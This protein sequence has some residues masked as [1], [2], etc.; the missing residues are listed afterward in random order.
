[1][2]RRPLG[3]TALALAS[4]LLASRAEALQVKAIEFAG[5][6]E[7]Q[8]LNV[9][10]ALSLARTQLD[11]TSVVSENRLD[12]LMRLA[13]REVRLGLEAFG[14]YDAQVESKLVR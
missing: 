5:L 3:L 11:A 9:R 7:A 13:P 6:D 12:Y 1:M 8:I 14:Y 2:T 10:S 4:L